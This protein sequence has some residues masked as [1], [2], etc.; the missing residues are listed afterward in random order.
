MGFQS[1]WASLEDGLEFLLKSL[2]SRKTEIIAAA[3]QF[4]GLWWC[5]HFQSSF[6]GGPTMSSKLL[7]EI[8][9]YGMP[10]SIDNYFSDE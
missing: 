2:D 9:S 10:L 5:R 4:E 7:T 6:D 8:G 3:R 1:E